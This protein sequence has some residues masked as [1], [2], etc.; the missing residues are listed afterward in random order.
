MPLADVTRRTFVAATGAAVAALAGLPQRILADPYAPIP[1]WRRKLAPIRVRG[2]V[3]IAGRAAPGVAVT[4]GHGV[5]L[6]ARDGSYSL[7]SASDRP[8]VSVSLPTGCR[9]PTSATG[10]ARMHAPITPDTRGEAIAR[11]DFDR[12]PGDDARHRFVVLADTQTQDAFEMTRLHAE[13]VPDVQRAMGNASAGQ[14]FGIACG[15]IMFDE[16]ALYP[17]YE[18][19]VA[20]MG[21]PFLQVVGNHDLNFDARTS[22]T[23]T[24][25]FERHFGPPWYSLNVG[26]IHYIVLNDVLWY[27]DGYL[28]YLT[29]EQLAWLAADLAAVERGRPV[30]VALHIPAGSTRWQR[31]SDRDEKRGETV[32]NKEA[33]LRLLEPYRAHLISGHTHEMEHLSYGGTEEHVLGTACGAW[34]SGDICHDG[35]PNGFGV[36]EAHGSDLRWTYHST[37]KPTE[38]Q[39]RVYPPGADSRAPDEVVANVWSWDPQWTVV[40]YANGERKGAMARRVG[41]DPQAVKEQTGPDLPARRKWVEPTPTAHLFYATPPDGTSEVVVEATDPW[42]HKFSERLALTAR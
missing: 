9:I 22:E 34:W 17:E 13:T 24:R 39:M 20:A 29:A 26:E 33:L 32:N 21:I 38:H 40:W 7:V 30:V 35:T 16:L 11:F 28:G 23:A 31:T 41:L 36:F 3:S 15:D 37:G 18:R 6:T 42:G 4:D 5:A 14:R 8:W 19:A 27:G 1:T 2:R 25:T 10:T 12:A